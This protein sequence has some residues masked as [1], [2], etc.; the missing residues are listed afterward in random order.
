MNARRQ[1]QAGITLTEVMI[2]VALFMLG[3]VGFFT[4]AS[5]LRDMVQLSNT[6]SE[7]TLVAGEAVERLRA[8][9]SGGAATGSYTSGTYTVSWA[10]STLPSCAARQVRVR[11][12]WTDVRGRPH[13]FLLPS[14]VEIR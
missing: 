10:A 7:A 8:Q 9:A 1:Q 14:I 11:V 5:S 2:A 6:T 13:A 3:A 4:L 12:A